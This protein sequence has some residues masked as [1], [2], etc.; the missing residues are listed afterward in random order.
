MH[1]SVIKIGALSA[2][3][4]LPVDPGLIGT[5]RP[6]GGSPAPLHATALSL[7]LGSGESYRYDMEGATVDSAAKAEQQ[8]GAKVL[9][10]LSL[11]IARGT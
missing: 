1:E 8:Q 9:N 7:T 10:G 6:I 11:S 3:R 4:E 2:V 5:A